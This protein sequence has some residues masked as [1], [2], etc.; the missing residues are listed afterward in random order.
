MIAKDIGHRNHFNNLK[1]EFFFFYFFLSCVQETSARV[2]LSNKSHLP[3]K[4]GFPDK[5]VLE[6]SPIVFYGNFIC[7]TLF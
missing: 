3:N 5:I 7:Y 1:L 4:M 2:L 6:A